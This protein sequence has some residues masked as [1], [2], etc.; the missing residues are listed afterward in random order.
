M[1]VVETHLMARD[2]FSRAIEDDETS[3]SGALVDTT[4]KPVAL[5]LSLC[6]RDALWQ[7]IVCHDELGGSG[8]FRVAIEVVVGVGASEMS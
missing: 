1:L 8:P 3:G 7:G 6:L 2:R 4:N 5:H